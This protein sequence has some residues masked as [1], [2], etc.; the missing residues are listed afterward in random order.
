M[1]VTSPITV[2][3]IPPFRV[4][5]TLD[6]LKRAARNERVMCQSGK[7]VW[8]SDGSPINDEAVLELLVKD[9]LDLMRLLVI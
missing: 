6:T 2:K 5:P 9:Q 3:T 8:T 4:N 1:Q 7:L